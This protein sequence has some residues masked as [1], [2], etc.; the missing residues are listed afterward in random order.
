[1]PPESGAFATEA[2]W[3][4]AYPQIVQWETGLAAEV[5]SSIEA[6]LRAAGQEPVEVEAEL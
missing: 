6:A 3:R 1:M 4:R 2:E 5:I